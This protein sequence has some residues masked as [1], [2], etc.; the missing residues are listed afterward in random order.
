MVYLVAIIMY[1]LRSTPRVLG[2]KGCICHFCK[3]ADTPFHTQGDAPTV[4]ADAT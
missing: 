2:M 4:N 3:V 1:L